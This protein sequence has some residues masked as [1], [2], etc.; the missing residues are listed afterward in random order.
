MQG[1]ISILNN[2]SWGQVQ[3]GTGEKGKKNSLAVLVYALLYRSYRSK[4]E[5]TSSRLYHSPPSL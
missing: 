2:H 5:N 4:G 1:G 3:G